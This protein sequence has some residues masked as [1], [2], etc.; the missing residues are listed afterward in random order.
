MVPEGGKVMAKAGWL[1]MRNVPKVSSKARAISDN[2]YFGALLDFF[3]NHTTC[4]KCKG[5]GF[6]LDES[7]QQI[8]VPEAVV[9][10]RGIEELEELS[11]QETVRM[12]DVIREILE[13]QSWKKRRC[14]GCKGSRFIRKDRIAELKKRMKHG[15]KIRQK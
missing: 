8:V 2:E 5:I 3:A 9:R 4:P 10:F 12:S 1:T 11:N 6:I 13:R 7:S 15:K 14:S